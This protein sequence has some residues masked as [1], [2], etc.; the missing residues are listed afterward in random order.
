VVIVILDMSATPHRHAA[1]P[2]DWAAEIDR[3]RELRS[4]SPRLGPG[5]RPALVVVDFQRAFMENDDPEAA[6]A[7]TATAELLDAAR[8]SGVPI[9]YSAMT[10]DSLDEVNV[11]WKALQDLSVFLRG[12]KPSEIDPR[13][14]MRWGDILVEKRHASSFFGTR[15]ADDLTRLGVDTLIVTGTS[16]SGCVRATAVDGCALSYRVM[17][18]EECCYDQR[19]V[20]RETALWDLADRYADVVV[21]KEMLDYFSS[22]RR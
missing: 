19:V 20:S 14:A 22:L 21:L 5:T 6:D 15:L 4:A 10:I 8:S 1:A 3:I 11:T 17:V 16:T 2:V 12:S 18:V 7:L 13:V 9:F